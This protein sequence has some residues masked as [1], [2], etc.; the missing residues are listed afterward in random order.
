MS[1]LNRARFG[2]SS[3]RLPGQS[4]LFDAAMDMPIPPEPAKVPVTR[5]ARRGRPALSKER[6]CQAHASNMT[7]ARNRRPHSTRLSVSAKS[8]GRRCIMSRH[9]SQSWTYPLQVCGEEGWRVDHRDG[10]R[11]ALAVAEE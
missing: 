10:E 9:S 5:Y 7:L 8:V 6:T 11:S 4:E 3:E 1:Q 2:A